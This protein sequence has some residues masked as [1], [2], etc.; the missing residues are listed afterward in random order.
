[1]SRRGWALFLAMGFIWGMPYLFIKEAVDSFAPAAVVSGRT[2][3]AA[4]LVLPIA[5]RTGALRPALARWPWVLAFGAIE[6]A[7]PF[8]LLSHAEQTL[9]S[10]LTGLLV[11]TVPLVAAVIGFAGGDRGALDAAR[12]AGLVVGI[13]GVALVVGGGG[14]GTIGVVPVAEVLL[15]AVCYAVAPF[16]VVRRLSDVPA[17]GPITLSLGA[18]GLAYLPVA[19]V[20]QDGA[21]TGR[22]IA[23]V[24]ALAVLCTALAFAVFFALIAEVGP[25]RAPLITYVNPVVALGLGVV[26]LDE[27]VTTAM[28]AGIPLVLVGCWFAAGAGRRAPAP[29]PLPVGE[30]GSEPAAGRSTPVS[31][32]KY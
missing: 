10:G 6:M 31:L 9:P 22:S 3:G 17:L 4:L 15:T 21:P 11:S 7:G 29:P 19:L 20:T 25:T 8:M 24:V 28:L 16:I 12:V 14:D 23:A 26:V 30:P 2:L 18:V 27:Q 13:A 1:M 32:D 5:A